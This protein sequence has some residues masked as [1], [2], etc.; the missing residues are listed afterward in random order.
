MPII[1]LGEEGEIISCVLVEY[2][3]FDYDHLQFF[4]VKPCVHLDCA[5]I[6]KVDYLR[7]LLQ[8]LTAIW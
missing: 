1:H 8:L 2:I 6:H 5:F 4:H 7:L 3:V